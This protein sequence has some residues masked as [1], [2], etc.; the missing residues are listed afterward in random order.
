[1]TTSQT[2]P[3]NSNGFITYELFSKYSKLGVSFKEVSNLPYLE[4]KLLKS[5]SV[6]VEGR[7]P[8]KTY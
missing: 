4:K 3:I 5:V 6:M 8:R 7:P 1:M 2:S